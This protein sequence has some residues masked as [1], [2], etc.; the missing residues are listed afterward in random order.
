MIVFVSCGA[1]KGSLASP[2]WRM[3]T[4]GYFKALFNYAQRLASL[5]NIYIV[6]AKYG[7]IQ[8]ETIIDTYEQQLGKLGSITLEQIREQASGIRVDPDVVVLGGMKYVSLVRNVFPHAQ[9]PLQDAGAN[10][11]G[12][13]ISLALKWA[14]EQ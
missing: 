4:G 1:K 2:A 7:L 6:S 12:Q 5:E 14:R 9:S 3:Y 11:M 8:S 13:Q 10:G